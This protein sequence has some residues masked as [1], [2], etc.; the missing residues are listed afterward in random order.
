MASQRWGTSGHG[1]Q[2]ADGRQRAATGGVG[3]AAA[4]APLCPA[5]RQARGH[6]LRYCSATAPRA[7]LASLTPGRSTSMAPAGEGG[8][9]RGSRGGRGREGGVRRRR[10]AGPPAWRLQGGD[11]R[12]GGRSR[13]GPWFGAWCLLHGRPAGPPAW[14]LHEDV[15]GGRRRHGR[16]ESHCRVAAAAADRPGL[17]PA[18]QR[19]PPSPPAHAQPRTAGQPGQA[20]PPAAPVASTG[21]LC[22]M[23]H[24]R[25]SGQVDTLSRA[26]RESTNSPMA[27]RKALT[28][29]SRTRAVRP[30]CLR[31]GSGE[32]SRRRA[33]Q[34]C[35]S[36][37]VRGRWAARCRRGLGRCRRMLRR[38]AQGRAAQAG[39]ATA[40]ARRSPPQAGVG[41][42]R[43]GVAGLQQAG[44]G[45]ARA[46]DQ[47]P[48]KDL[49][50]LELR[51][52]R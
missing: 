36:A 40:N 11:A 46:A 38:A 13:G 34:R 14:R 43:G 18:Q 31:G 23:R 29:G 2:S 17:E 42:P 45:E 9:E 10:I 25:T 30:R 20:A 1:G 5:G 51:Q 12:V 47:V 44:Q 50:Q 39:A 41:A 26:L 3:A 8:G 15:A 16:R 28:R 6:T 37:E 4:P 27:R 48:P 19:L 21:Q 22:R 32:R 35:E 33:G 24:T 7:L 52:P 49:L